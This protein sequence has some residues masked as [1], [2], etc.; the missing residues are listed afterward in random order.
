[1]IKEKIDVSIC[2]IFLFLFFLLIWLVELVI[3]FLT[4]LLIIQ[5]K[6]GEKETNEKMKLV[7]EKQ[8]VVKKKGEKKIP[9]QS[10]TCLA[11]TISLIM[12]FLLI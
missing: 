1:M 2:E 10:L 7:E 9:W 11:K 3:D 5:K 4:Y 8:A 6:G 12:D